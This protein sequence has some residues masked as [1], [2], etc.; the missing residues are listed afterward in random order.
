MIVLNLYKLSLIAKRYILDGFERNSF[1]SLDSIANIFVLIWRRGLF[2]TLL[3]RYLLFRPKDIKI[4]N[5]KELNY[6]RYLTFNASPAPM[7]PDGSANSDP[8]INMANPVTTLPTVEANMK[9]LIK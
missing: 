9:K 2:L 8:P 3:L 4:L 5:S 1:V 7:I 6:S